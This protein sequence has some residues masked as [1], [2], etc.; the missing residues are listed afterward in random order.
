VADREEGDRGRSDWEVLKGDALQATVILLAIAVGMLLVKFATGLLADWKPEALATLI[1]GLLAVM[2]AIWIGIKQAEIQSRQVRLQETDVR[3]QVLDK[4]L[5]AIQKLEEWLSLIERREGGRGALSE[6]RKL[7]NNASYLFD[8]KTAISLDVLCDSISNCIG[9]N[10][11]EVLFE[12]DVIG[13]YFDHE[14]A[15][16]DIYDECRLITREII[17]VMKEASRVDL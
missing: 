9:R 7:I 2:G 3:I 6:Y 15:I 11:S 5:D 17:S 12:G 1:A 8:K 10:E 4:R 14:D 13:Q 16:R